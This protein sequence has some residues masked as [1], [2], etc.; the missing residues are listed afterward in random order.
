YQYR[1][2]TITADTESKD[3]ASS[4]PGTDLK[5]KMENFEKY[6]IEKTLR[7]HGNNIYKTANEL[8]I[9]RQSLQYRLK[10]FGLD[11]LK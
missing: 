8:G 6:M 9:S 1:M 4:Q 11:R 3:A 10:K 5:D 2:N 7:K